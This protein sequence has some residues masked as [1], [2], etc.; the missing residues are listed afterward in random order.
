[1][2]QT[3]NW[4]IY[5]YMHVPSGYLTVRHGK[6]PS[7]CPRQII[8]IGIQEQLHLEAVEITW[9]PLMV[10]MGLGWA[11]HGHKKRPMTISI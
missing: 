2:F 6:S 3:I 9:G 5:I 11:K 7:Q 1:M 4:Y 8:P 10:G